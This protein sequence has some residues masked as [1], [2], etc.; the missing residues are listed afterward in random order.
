[1]ILRHF[2]A[3]LDE[4]Y[5]TPDNLSRHKNRHLSSRDAAV[6]NIIEERARQLS[7]DTNSIEG[8]I[9]TRTATLDMIIAQGL[10]SLR[11]GLTSSEPKDMLAA[12]QM[13][14]K[15]EQDFASVAV[16]EMTLQ[17]KAFADAVQDVVTP[18]QGAAIFERTKELLSERQIGTKVIRPEIP[19]TTTIEST[20]YTDE[21]D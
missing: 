18:E 14:E 15:M 3:V 17:Y 21:E 10:E 11:A 6:R 19:K 12:I 1:M 8:F 9:L 4:E 16:E 2:N 20:D 5:F 7:M 13:L